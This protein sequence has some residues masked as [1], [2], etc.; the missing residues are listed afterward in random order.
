MYNDKSGGMNHNQDDSKWEVG[1]QS[2]RGSRPLRYLLRILILFMLGLM[3]MTCNNNGGGGTKETFRNP[4]EIFSRNGV[5]DTMFRVKFSRIRIGDKRV[6]TSVY[7][8]TFVPPTLRVFPGDLLKIRLKND[9]DQMTNLHYHGM[10]V[11]PLS[12]S[13]DIFIMI[14]PTADFDYEAN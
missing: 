12:P 1:K 5:L 7:N 10:N 6:T 8:G 2:S 14:T 4:K 3:S 11:P 13:D 9:I